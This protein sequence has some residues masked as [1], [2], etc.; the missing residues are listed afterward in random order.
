[1]ESE[2]TRLGKVERVLLFVD[3]HDVL[4]R[5]GTV[6]EL[7]PLD[8]YAKNPVV[9]AEQDLEHVIGY[10]SVYRDPKS[11]EYQL[12]YQAVPGNWLSY[13]TSR[14]GQEWEKPRV[15]PDGSNRLLPIGYGAGASGVCRPRGAAIR[16]L[17]DRPDSSPVRRGRGHRAARPRC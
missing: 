3:D 8:R 15:G 17:R 14:D 1:M 7:R 6:R 10:C 2:P 11:G 9:P 13:A 12:W 4:Y 5:P 16:S